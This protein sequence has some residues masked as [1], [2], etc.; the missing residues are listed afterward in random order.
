MALF[1][2]SNISE[3]TKTYTLS[4]E[5][6]K[7]CIRVLRKK[8]DDEIELINGKGGQFFAVICDA[9][10]K[11]CQVE[12]TRTIFHSPSKSIHIGL[13]PTKNMDRIEWFVEKA[14][15]LGLTK[16]SFLSCTNNER[17]T[18]KLERVNKIAIGAMKQ[19][20][21]FYL[22][23]ICELSPFNIFVSN[24]PGGYIGHCYE[25]KKQ[26]MAA[27]KT[28][29]VFLIGPEGD[30]TEKEVQLALENDYTAITLSTFRLRTETAALMAVFGLN[31]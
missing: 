9:H 1:Y 21:R 28:S 16:L 10:E 29:A 5:E 31:A 19:S 23:E 18:V 13:A 2:A 4:E 20:K 15:E 8:K 12:I 30:F 22:P 11:R 27:L 24:N 26:R 6:S 7:H 3:I 14:T 17:N 25:S